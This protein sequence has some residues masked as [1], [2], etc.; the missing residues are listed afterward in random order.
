[1]FDVQFARQN[2]YEPPP[3]FPAASSLSSIVYH[4]LGPNRCA[5]TQILL[6]VE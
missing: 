2:G 5:L 1:M 4:L 3:E 6:G